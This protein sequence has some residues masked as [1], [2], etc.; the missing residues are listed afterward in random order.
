MRLLVRG[1]RSKF[2]TMAQKLRRI[3]M[4]STLAR[5]CYFTMYLSDVK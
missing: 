4:S 3:R 1:M 2:D 5:K